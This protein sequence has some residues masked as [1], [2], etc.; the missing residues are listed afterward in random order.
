MNNNKNNITDG[1]FIMTRKTIKEL[2][3]IIEDLEN[4][5]KWCMNIINDRNKQIEKIAD[6]RFE[7][8]SLYKMM[9]KEINVLEVVIESQKILIKGKEIDIKKYIETIDKL[10]KENLRLS[11]NLCKWF[12]ILKNITGNFDFQ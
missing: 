7:N 5:L 4:R 11:I 8:S 3:K 9:N 10:L 12:Y 1:V 6:D 2:E